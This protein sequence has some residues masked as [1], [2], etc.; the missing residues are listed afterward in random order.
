MGLVARSIASIPAGDYT[1]YVILLEEDWKDTISAEVRD[2]FDT[3]VRKAGPNALVVRGLEKEPFS[4][5]VLQAYD[6]KGEPQMP[7]LVV[8]DTTPF[9]ALRRPR[10]STIPTTIVI[11]LRIRGDAKGSVRDVLSGLAGALRNN[12]P[13]ALR[14]LDKSKLE[15]N[16]GWLRWLELKPNFWGVGLNVNEIVED[17]FFRTK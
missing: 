1:W 9:D 12:D 16:W 11:P 17:L 14:A 5:E 8:S 10:G 15:K 7:A 4:D 13:K 6:L 3:L 2:N